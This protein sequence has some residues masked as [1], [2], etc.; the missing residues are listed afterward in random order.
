M[1]EKCLNLD[2]ICYRP[3]PLPGRFG[4]VLRS[5]VRPRLGVWLLLIVAG[6]L[7]PLS[8]LHAAP[9]NMAVMGDSLN[10]LTPDYD[11]SWVVQLQNAGAI[12]PYDVARDARGP[13]TSTTTNCRKCSRTSSRG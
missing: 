9:I 1:F 13:T 12:T 10:L 5:S 11:T 3:L 2:V 8:V 7:W 6:P 4:R